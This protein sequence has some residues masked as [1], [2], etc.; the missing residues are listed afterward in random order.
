MHFLQTLKVEKG[1]G[2]TFELITDNLFL[3]TMLEILIRQGI[4]AKT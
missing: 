3:C 1:Y 2:Q 4:K